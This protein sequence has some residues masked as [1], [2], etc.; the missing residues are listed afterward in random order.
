M[1]GWH[2][3]LVQISINTGDLPA[4]EVEELRNAERLR[5]AELAAQGHVIALWRV[6]NRWANRGIWRARDRAELDGILASLPLRPYMMIEVEELLEHPS[7]PRLAGA[8]PSTSSNALPP[9]PELVLRLRSSKTVSWGRAP[10]SMD[11]LPDL[12]VIRRDEKVLT[13]SILGAGIVTVYRDVPV[14]VMPLDMSSVETALRVIDK[15][16]PAFAGM[17]RMVTHS[18]AHGARGAL[19]RCV[20]AIV[21][22]VGGATPTAA[23]VTSGD[24][25]RAIVVRDEVRLT[26][27]VPDVPVEVV[28]ACLGELCVSLSV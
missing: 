2:E 10:I 18:G 26:L 15:V 19:T 28:A 8:S 17:P 27:S 22:D 3:F 1:S 23:V 25:S 11:S 6:S 12:T 16:E 14:S 7:D 9:L 24:G 20:D 5:A 13:P 21:L 4:G